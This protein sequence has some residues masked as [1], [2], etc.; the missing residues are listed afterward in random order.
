M[1]ERTWSTPHLATH[2]TR[3]PGPDGGG[4]DP[5][6]SATM[7]TQSAPTSAHMQDGSTARKRARACDEAQREHEQQKQDDLRRTIMQELECV[8]CMTAMHQGI[9]QCMN[10]HVV[11][12]ECKPRLRGT[13]ATCRVPLG[14][15]RNRAMERIA[16]CIEMP[17]RFSDSGCTASLTGALREQHEC[18]CSFRPFACPL[19]ASCP[20]EGSL[21][22][23][24]AHLQS[25][26]R[27]PRRDNFKLAL[28]HSSASFLE[29]T[30]SASAFLFE[31]H[32][33]ELLFLW[34]QTVHL[35][36]A[37]VLTFSTSRT[38]E[39]T[40]AVAAR[41]RTISWT[42]PVRS[43]RDGEGVLKSNDCLSVPQSLVGWLSDSPPDSDELS[44]AVSVEVVPIAPP[45]PKQQGAAIKPA[46]STGSAVPTTSSAMGGGGGGGVV[47]RRVS[48]GADAQDVPPTMSQSAQA[49]PINY[50]R[51]GALSASMRRWLGNRGERGRV[52]LEVTACSH[53]AL[54]PRLQ[55]QD[56]GGA[57]G[58]PRCP[59]AD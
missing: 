34:S 52:E 36:Q 44:L 15:T 23:L 14:D 27:V 32:G 48:F 46:G 53:A 33:Q 22:D 4:V 38:H 3:T 50:M 11:C 18:G 6:L 7:V 47:V 8:V 54:R 1:E 39:Y 19:S 10:G 45:P 49:Q 35:L 40:L 26:H 25:A 12:G 24:S 16:A 9:Y 21:E 51:G 30:G 28:L 56:A 43:V 58:T 20:F 41:G 57:G 31:E 55:L 17:C 29:S 5:P 37:C 42:A 2:G 59:A 13:C